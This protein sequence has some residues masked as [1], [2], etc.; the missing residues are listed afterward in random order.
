MVSAPNDP[1]TAKK[2]SAI[3]TVAA[4]ARPIAAAAVDW[5]ESAS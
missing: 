2:P 5:P 1:N 4:S 3:P